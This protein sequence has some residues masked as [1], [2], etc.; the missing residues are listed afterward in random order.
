[1][2]D[3]N[4]TTDDLP[5]PVLRIIE[6]VERDSLLGDL[7]QS[8]RDQLVEQ[9]ISAKPPE[10]LYDHA[11]T[12]VDYVIYLQQTE[13]PTQAATIT[14]LIRALIPALERLKDHRASAAAKT[15]KWLEQ[16]EGRAS[17]ALPDK[18]APAPEGSVG[19]GPFARFALRDRKL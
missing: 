2:T 11:R 19:A 6:A 9:L 7:T 13:R 14:A 10:A 1:V 15:Q 4:A 5:E 16:I 3:S 12:L 17:A 8:K 18:T